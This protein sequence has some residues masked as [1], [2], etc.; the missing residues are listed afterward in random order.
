MA[1]AWVVVALLEWTAWLDEPHYGRGLPPRY[2]V[3]HVALPPAGRAV[4]Q[5]EPA[6][7]ILPA[8]DD[9]PTFV[10]STQEW[11]LAAPN[12]RMA[13]ADG[14]RRA[15]RTRRASCRCRRR[16]RRSRRRSRRRS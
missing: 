16:S 14:R 10:A 13:E 1:V 8:V 5:G 2:Y 9:E 7:P 12:G 6:Y 4:R 15:T 11:G 3:P